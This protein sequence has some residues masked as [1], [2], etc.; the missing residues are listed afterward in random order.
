MHSTGGSTGPGQVLLEVDADSEGE[1]G[2]FFVWEPSEVEAVLGGEKA[3]RF[4]AAYDVTAAGNWEGKSILRLTRPLAE[5]ADELGM[6]E[7]A[8]KAELAESRQKLFEQREQ[9][10]KPGRDEKV[11]TAWNGMMLAAFAEAARVLDRADYR[12]AASKNADFILRELRYEGRL[13]RSWKAGQAKLM[14]YLE[15]YAFVAEG[16]LALYQTTFDERWFVEAQSLGNTI[17]NHFND[18]QDGGF[19]DTADDHEQLVVR[20]KSIQDNATPA[21][22]SLAVTVLLQLASYTGDSTYYDPAVKSLGAVQQALTQYASAFAQWL[23][24]LEYALAPA[25]EVALIGRPAEPGMAAMLSTL[26]GPFRPNQV[27]ALAETPTSE[28]LIPLLNDR[29][30]KDG[31]STAYVCQNFACQLPVNTAEALAKQL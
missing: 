6:A 5:V 2:K 22:N 21:G 8:F 28:S 30:L 4:A 12:A 11:L 15:D 1:E 20:P 14:G 10:I 27:V 3:G 19:F 29:P 23:V 26:Q 18:P 13:F 31:H 7:D 17:L 9:R 16:L 24:S 25:K